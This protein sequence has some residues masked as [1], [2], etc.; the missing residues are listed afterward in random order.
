MPG[1]VRV[2]HASLDRAKHLSA[3]G[4]FKPGRARLTRAPPLV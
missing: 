1:G 2:K 4:W 3:F